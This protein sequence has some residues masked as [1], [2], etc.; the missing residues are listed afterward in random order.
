MALTLPRKTVNRNQ[1]GDKIGKSE[2][3]KQT[4]KQTNK[5]LE[6]IKTNKEKER[7]TG[8]KKECY[9]AMNSLLQEVDI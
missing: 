4:N 6:T 8:R 9:A 3:D 5:C 7:R 2:T 1:V